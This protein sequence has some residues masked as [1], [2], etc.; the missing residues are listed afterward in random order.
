MGVGQLARHR[1]AN[2]A[3]PG[4][5]PPPPPSPRVVTV[6][7]AARGVK[8]GSPRPPPP[9]YC[10]PWCTLPIRSLIHQPSFSFWPPTAIWPCEVILWRADSSKLAEASWWWQVGGSKLAMASE[11]QQV[12]P[13]HYRTTA[14]NAGELFSDVA[15]D[16][17]SQ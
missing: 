3:A 7:T 12:V 8:M 17:F 15:L 10:L 1:A 2:T 5:E 4:L 6:A 11:L 13:F 14:H 16:H 9:S